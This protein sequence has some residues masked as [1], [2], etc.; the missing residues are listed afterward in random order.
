[1]LA[2]YLFYAW[3]DWRFLGVVLFSTIIDY[4]CALKIDQH[5]FRKHR[6]KY[7]FLSLSVNLLLL[8]FFKYFHFFI[9]NFILLFQ[10]MGVQLQPSTLQI[11]LPIGISFFTFQTMSYTIDVYRKKIKPTK[12]FIDYA[13]FIAFFPKLIAGP[14]ERANRFLP[15]IERQ[16]ELSVDK[17]KSGLLLIYWG[18]FKKLVIADNLG[19][20]I[21]YFSARNSEE[22]TSALVWG[23]LYGY[24]IQLYADFSAYTDIAR[25]T[26]RL[27]GFELSHNFRNPVFSRNIQDF[28]Q[29]WHISLTSWFTD[30]VFLPLATIKLKYRAIIPYAAIFFTF[31]LVGLWHGAGWN[32]LLWGG[33]NGAALAGYHFFKRKKNHQIKKKIARALPLGDLV[34]MAVTLN[35]VIIGLI[36]FRSASLARAIHCFSLILSNFSF[37]AS[38]WD[39]LFKVA[40]YSAPLLIAE[41]FLAKND[42]DISQFFR[43][44]K[45]IRFGIL[46]FMLFLLVVYHDGAHQFIYFQF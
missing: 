6:R 27:M 13:L 29:R 25:G 24:A 32:F 18:L 39:L 8:G 4:F 15:Q 44:P 3:W 1:M 33:Y 7:L 21:S 46:Y 43:L 38:E 41:I 26:A 12:N 40:I 17:L 2:S 34:A 9:D 30:Y 19:T 22:L 16:R 20:M 31:L 42:N 45:L 36:F 37:G 35:F 28:W 23:T 10:K 5:D 11:I 14:I